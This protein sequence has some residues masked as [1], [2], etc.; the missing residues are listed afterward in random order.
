MQQGNCLENFAENS[1]GPN[2]PVN[3]AENSVGVIHNK[4]QDIAAAVVHGKG[5]EVVSG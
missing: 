2:Y 4:A 1:D 3:F 5:L